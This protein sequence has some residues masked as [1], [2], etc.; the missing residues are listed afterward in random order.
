VIFDV[1]VAHLH[2]TLDA[3]RQ[4]YSLRV[5][6]VTLRVD[7]AC[8]RG[9]ARVTHALSAS[10]NAL[11]SRSR[12]FC[13]RKMI[14]IGMMLMTMALISDVGVFDGLHICSNRVM[15]VAWWRG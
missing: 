3:H 11:A 13:L 10:I 6:G 14:C 15:V 9:L 1:R 4:H 5:D 8:A 2:F 12:A 7:N